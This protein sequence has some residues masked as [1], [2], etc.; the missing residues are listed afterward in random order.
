M[1]DWRIIMKKEETKIVDLYDLFH[2]QA[3][4]FLRQFTYPWEALA[5]IKEFILE[6]GKTLP[7]DEY[8]RRGET[9]W[10]HKT[11]RVMPSAFLGENIIIGKDTEV[12][13]CAFLRGNALV[14]EGAVVGN[15]TELK[16]VILF[17]KVQV[18][19]YNYVGDSILGYRAHMGAGSITSNVKSDKKL[20]VVKSPEGNIETGM[21][22]FGAM[23]GDEVEVGC[24]T[25]L[26]PGSVVGSHSNIYPL[27][28]VRG[29]VPANS[30][31]KKQGEVVEK[32]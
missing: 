20:V 29:F 23:L 21:K 4:D 12:R 11:A 6:L 1:A 9:V 31:Y 25:V 17:D 8:E 19:H 7:E 10:V 14:G 26:N 24:G 32:Y 13:H 28:S 22:K 30:I 18:P 27:S 3:A 5:H 2:T 16:N 15:S